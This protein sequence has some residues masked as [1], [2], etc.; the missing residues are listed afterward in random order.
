MRGPGSTTQK[1]LIRGGFLVVL[2]ASAVAVWQGAAG[3]A[4]SLHWVTA[5]IEFQNSNC[6]FTTGA[7]RIGVA[8]FTRQDDLM[9]VEYRLQH[10]DAGS[11]YDVQLYDGDGCDPIADLGPIKTN[12]SGSGH[13][14]FRVDV[15]GH[16]S[17]FVTGFN[18]G[19]NDSLIVTLP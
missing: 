5:P 14:T 19:A 4:S 11:V 15:A 2:V 13:K 18:P 6:G 9:Q 12:A 8:K 17:F 10:G 7:S 3:A 16:S 1:R